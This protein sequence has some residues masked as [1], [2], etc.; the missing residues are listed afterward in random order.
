[1]C[2]NNTSLTLYANEVKTL[3]HFGSVLLHPV[4]SDLHVRDV[5][6]FIVYPRSHLYVAI[7]P[8]ATTVPLTGVAGV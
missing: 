7:D 2:D 4:P 6:P 8:L 1:M 3:Q 5:M